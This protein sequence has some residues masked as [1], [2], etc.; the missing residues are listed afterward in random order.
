MYCT[1]CGT[2]LDDN[3]KFCTKCGADQTKAAA[4]AAAVPAPV[5]SQSI[6]LEPIAPARKPAALKIVSI[7]AAAAIALGLGVAGFI[8]I[9]KLLAGSRPKANNCVAVTLDAIE[10]IA[11]LSSFEYKIE[12]DGGEENFAISGYLSLGKDLYDSAFELRADSGDDSYRSETRA[13]FHG[14][15]LGTYS[16]SFYDD[17]GDYESYEYMAVEELLEGVFDMLSEMG[18]DVDA[19]GFDMRNL[20]KNGRFNNDEFNK[21]SEKLSDLFDPSTLSDLLDDFGADEF[22]DDLD[23]SKYLDK[24]PKI[25]EE[26]NKMV[27]GFFYVACE[28]EAFL[29]EFVSGLDVAKNKDST[30]YKFAVNPSKLAGSL[31]KYIIDNVTKYPEIS[32]LLEEIADSRKMTLDEFLSFASYNMRVAFE[33]MGDAGDIRFSLTVSKDRL[34]ENLTVSFD[35]ESWDYDYSTGEY[36][37]SALTVSVRITLSNHNKVKP[38]LDEIENFMAIANKNAD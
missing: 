12:V 29:S 31:T 24:L 37:T 18:I 20:V 32:G 27:E 4:P 36:K 13:L 15:H 2:Q 3:A 28:K 22:A 34:P 9:P 35:T 38:D 6:T 7:V 33:E 8:F 11:G 21:I 30:T 1:E 25:G 17:W 14:G 10:N 19:I 16:S 5:Q 26:L 23:I